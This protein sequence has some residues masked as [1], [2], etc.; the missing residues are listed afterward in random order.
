MEAAG[1]F[2]AGRDPAGAAYHCAQTKAE[3]AISAS[4][5]RQTGCTFP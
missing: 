4:E 2:N 3:E 1:R 5:H